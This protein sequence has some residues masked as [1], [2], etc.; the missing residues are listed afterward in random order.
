MKASHF[1]PFENLVHL[2]SETFA[3]IMEEKRYNFRISVG[4]SEDFENLEAAARLVLQLTS[5]S[6][7]GTAKRAKSWKTTKAI[8]A[9]N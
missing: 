8:R 9:V 3:F 6:Q 4:M 2:T 5:G 1:A 7:E